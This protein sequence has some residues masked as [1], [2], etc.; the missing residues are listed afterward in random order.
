MSDTAK[1]EFKSEP[2]GPEAPPAP[3]PQTPQ[4]REDGQPGWLPENFKT[5]DAFVASYGEAQAELTRAKQELAKVKPGETPPAAPK[6]GEPPAAK[7][8]GEEGT[9]PKLKIEDAKPETPEAAAKAAVEKAGLDVSAWQTEFNETGDVS[10]E[11]R[12]KIAEGLKSVFGENAKQVVDDFIEG[13]K[14]R[15]VNFIEESTKEVGGV[16]G[17]QKIAQWASKNLPEAEVKAINKVLEG[18][19]LASTK[20]ALAGL[21]AKFEKANG[22]DPQL[23]TGDNVP[24]G[25]DTGKFASQAELVKAVSDPRYKTDPAYRARIEKRMMAS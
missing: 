21:Q 9:P 24:T 20:L 15:A 5:V 23:I 10:A 16:E 3:A 19:D 1:V 8:E 2:T 11:G 22:S 7:K 18:N 12:E 17:F 13:Q 14:M 25:G 4:A 6:E